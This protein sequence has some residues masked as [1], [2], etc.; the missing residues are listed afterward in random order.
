MPN[1]A[2]QVSFN[3]W[4]H[5]QCRPLLKARD[6]RCAAHCQLSLKHLSRQGRKPTKWSNILGKRGH[7]CSLLDWCA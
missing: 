4:D 7:E 2:V 6:E 3:R 1:R 5:P